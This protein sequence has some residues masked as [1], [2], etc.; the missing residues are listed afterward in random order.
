MQRV[1]TGVVLASLMVVLVFRA[2][3]D[4][5]KAVVLGIAVLAGLE[6]VRI[7]RQLAPNPGLALLPLL[8][9]LLAS[10]QWGWVS[11]GPS[12]Q[13]AVLGLLGAFVALAVLLVSKGDVPSRDPLMVPAAA[14][15]LAFGAA[16]LGA[17]AG[18]MGSLHALDPWLFFLAVATVAISDTAAY[19]GGRATGKNKLAPAVSPNKTIEGSL[20]GLAAAVALVAAYSWLRLGRIEPWLLALGAATAVAGQLGDLVE[21]AFKRAAGVKDSGSLLPGHGGVLD[22]IDALLLAAPVLYLGL[23]ALGPERFV[24]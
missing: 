4:V 20:W 21:S 15:L 7:A 17:A 23:Q 18:A 22:R 1:I 6:L 8:A 2:S 14:G 19:Y 12:A 3:N 24:P 9:P 10:W 11:F 16:Y 13:T 5:F